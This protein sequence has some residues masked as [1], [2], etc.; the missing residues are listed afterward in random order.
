MAKNVQLNL[1]E[2]NNSLLRVEKNWAEIDDNLAKLRIGKKDV[3]FNKELRERM[4]SAY[5][6]LN[7]LLLRHVEPFSES[8]LDKMLELNHLVHFGSDNSLRLEYH[9]AVLASNDKF[10]KNIGVISSWYKKHKEHK[11][12]PLKIAAEIYVGTVG[13]PQLFIEGNHRT[14]S[15]IASWINMYHG[16]APFVLSVDNAIAF[17][18][19]SS[20]IKF[21]SDKSTWV[22]RIKLPK[23]K[24]SFRNFWENHLEDKYILRD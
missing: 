5:A 8:S 19:P 18:E 13:Y 23:Y 21:F 15:I 12:H 6:Y 20:E 22:G 1:A 24:K 14:G 11:D 17:F 2:I 10:Y 9:A 3:P 7:P 16:Y 4:M